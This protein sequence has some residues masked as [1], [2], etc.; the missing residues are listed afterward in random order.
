MPN[1]KFH[2][3]GAAMIPDSEIYAL[4][5]FQRNAKSHIRRLRKTGRPEILTVNG[6]AA[7]VIQD[8]ETYRRAMAAAAHAAEIAAVD[9][10]LE[11]MK[12][13]LGIPLEQ[14]DRQLRKE[15]AR[16]RAPRR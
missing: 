15:F 10:A 14:V 13:G 9:E 7:V 16:R 1:M 5:D 11:Q 12:A 3:A 8:A 4:S 2:D 6:R